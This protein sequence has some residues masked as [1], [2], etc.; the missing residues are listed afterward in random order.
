MRYIAR[1]DTLEVQSLYLIRNDFENVD[2]AINLG[3]PIHEHATN[4]A[5]AKSLTML[6]DHVAH[7]E[8]PVRIPNT[9]R[10]ALSRLWN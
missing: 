6:A 9:L 1:I 7:L 4:S 5:V 10:R 8:K 3:V 2:A